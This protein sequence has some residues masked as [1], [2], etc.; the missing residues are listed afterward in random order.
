MALILCIE[1]STEYCSV[2]VA[3]DGNVIS[4]IISTEVNTHAKLLTLHIEK[5]L[6]I[7]G[8]SIQ[9]IDAVAVSAGPGS[10]TGLRIGVSCAKGICYAL[11]KPFIT[12]STLQLLGAALLHRQNKANL[13]MPTLKSRAGEF[14][15]AL[16]NQ[17]LQEVIHPF[18]YRNGTSLPQEIEAVTNEIVVGGNVPDVDKYELISV[19]FVT[20]LSLLP[21]AVHMAQIAEKM[22][23]NALFSDVSAHEPAYIQEFIPKLKSI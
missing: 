12:I 21:E 13:V 15:A 14:Y 6:Q 10:F 3:Q 2:C 5:V 16:Y 17:G 18:V 22:Y 8:L 19:T 9:Q 7:A 23:Q 11:G 20:Y 4:K 1:T